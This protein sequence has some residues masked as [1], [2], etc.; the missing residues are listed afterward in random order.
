M[1]EPEETKED[2]SRKRTRRFVLP[3]NNVQYNSTFLLSDHLRHPRPALHQALHR[4]RRPVPQIPAGPTQI[5]IIPIRA[6]V[7]GNPAANDVV[8]APDL[9]LHHLVERIQII[10]EAGDVGLNPYLCWSFF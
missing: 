10:L 7:S 8:V 6:P 5:L 3:L 4:L 2:S 9:F 1:K